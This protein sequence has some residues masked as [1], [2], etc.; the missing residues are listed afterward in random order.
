MLTI[1]ELFT[2]LLLICNAMC[3]ILLF[4]NDLIVGLQF[5]LQKKLSFWYYFYLVTSPIYFTHSYPYLFVLFGCWICCC[6]FQ[7]NNM[8]YHYYYL[9]ILI[10][11][12][13]IPI[14][15]PIPIILI[16]FILILFIILIIIL[17]LF[18]ILI[19][20]SIY[21]SVILIC[22]MYVKSFLY[23]FITLLNFIHFLLFILK[24]IPIIFWCSHAR[25]HPHVISHILIKTIV[26]PFTH[27][28][29]KILHLYHSYYVRIVLNF[30]VLHL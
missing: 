16:L 8:S 22:F 21:I 1:Y 28:F 14:P 20:I 11:I 10:P 24:T 17:I 26:I 25:A 15:I 23:N 3:T 7:T 27:A 30:S 4:F 19:I 6:F 12:I 2:V 5:I 13:P 29:L 18:I 9:I